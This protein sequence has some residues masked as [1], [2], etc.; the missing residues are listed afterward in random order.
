MDKKT[1][2]L[3]EARARI[4]KALA[5]SSRLYM[6]SELASGERCVCELA[7]MIDADISTASKH[8]AVLKSAG[9]VQIDKRGSQVFYSLKLPCVLNFLSCVEDVMQSSAEEI[10]SCCRR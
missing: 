1:K 5:H 9:I 7:K 10:L 4:L 2:N 6:V 8:L 3:F